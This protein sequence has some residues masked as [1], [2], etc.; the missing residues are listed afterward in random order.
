MVIRI[1]ALNWNGNV[2]EAPITLMN[3]R[4]F[5]SFIGEPSNGAIMLTWDEV[6]FAESCTLYNL[7]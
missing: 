5:P 7:H 1:V 6:A 3:A 4:A 2:A